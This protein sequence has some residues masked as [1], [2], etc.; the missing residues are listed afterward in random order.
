[1]SVVMPLYTITINDG[2]Y[3]LSG[4]AHAVNVA[5]VNAGLA[6]GLITF[7]GDAATQKV[8]INFTAAGIRIDFTGA[9]S[10]RGI[11]G[12]NSA[13]V[14][15]AYT[16]DILSVYADTVATFNNIYYFLLHSNIV[17][18]GIPV[19]G[20]STS[21]IA[22]VLIDTTPGNQIIFSPQNP[23]KIPAQSLAGRS[24]N[25]LHFWLTDQSNV[26]RDQNQEDFSILLVIKYQM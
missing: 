16:T 13:V 18:G 2:L 23:V 17:A 11:L 15:A 4:F 24:I 14:P 20:N 10:C 9:N 25:T 8:V 7:T 3:D 6:N 19:N 5:I 12:F 26:Q 1:M 21:V 22:R